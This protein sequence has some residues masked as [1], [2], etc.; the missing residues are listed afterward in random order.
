M[1][2]SNVDVGIVMDGTGELTV[3]AADLSTTTR[4]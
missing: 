2:I 3:E 1:T 4:S